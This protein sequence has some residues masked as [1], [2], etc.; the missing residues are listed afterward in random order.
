MKKKAFV[1]I[2]LGLLAAAMLLTACSGNPSP[3]SQSSSGAGGSSATGSDSAGEP[4]EL[5]WYTSLSDVMAGKDGM[6]EAANQYIQQKLGV[7]VDFHIYNSSEY[8]KTVSTI[9]SSGAYMDILFTGTNGGVDFNTNAV[10]NAFVPLE[11]Y[12]DQY[13]PGTKEQLPERAWDAF[14]LNGHIY[15]VPPMKDLAA[16]WG[17][18]ANQTMMDDLGVTFPEK[19]DTAYDLIP[20]LNEVKEARDA[21]YPDKA[22]NPIISYA[23]NRLDRFY[24]FEGIVV[25][26]DRAA[27]LAIAN[28]PGLSGFEGQG[29]G[30]SVF[31]PFYTQEYRDYLKQVRALV[32]EGIAPFDEDSFDPDKVLFNAGELLGSYP[33]GYVYVDED[34]YAPYYKARH[35]ESENA[36]MTTAIIQNGAQAIS[37]TSTNVE[38]ALEL[39]ELVN[40]DSYLATTLRFG[41][42]GSNWTDEDG[43]GLFEDGPQNADV[44]NRN[45]YNWYGWQFGSIIVSKYPQGYPANFAELVKQLNDNSNQDSNLGFIFNPDPVTNEIAACN[46][47]VE[48]Y[49]GTLNKG[50]VDDID[51]QVD[52]FVQKLKDNGCDKIVEEAQSQLTAWRKSVGKTTK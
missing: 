26:N 24:Y 48:E 3:S 52:A 47:V 44:S 5:V 17:F 13:L 18:L 45:W 41:P 51:A 7:T 42:E 19:F 29:D 23:F 33:L 28:V 20:F 21:K 34:M 6:V 25:G 37:S 22:E 9:L 14:T 35:Y 15:A 46:N 32:A 8:T 12:I 16:R 43:D 1:K 10:R 40:N 27:P 4:T 50:Q 39:L 49:H 11:D 2:L 36:L 31:C 30:E 38:R